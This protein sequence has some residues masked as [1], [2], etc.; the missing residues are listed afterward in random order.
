[1]W[2]FRNRRKEQI[3][4][5]TQDAAESRTVMYSKLFELDKLDHALDEMV[6]HS[7]ELLKPGRHEPP[8]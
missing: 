3:A 5:L 6:R 2:P 7:L 8:E 1:M 4:K